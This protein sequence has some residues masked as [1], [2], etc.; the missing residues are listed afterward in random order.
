[1]RQRT[2]ILR[3]RARPEFWS[4]EMFAAQFAVGRCPDRRVQRRDGTAAAQVTSA[5]LARV[6]G[7]AFPQKAEHSQIAVRAMDAGA[8]QFDQLAANPLVGR[9]TKLF[10]AV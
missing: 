3:L 5:V 2:F 1:M 4:G 9:E 10:L 6:V 8:A 7:D